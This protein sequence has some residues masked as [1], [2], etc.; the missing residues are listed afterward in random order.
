MNNTLHIFG[1]SYSQLTQEYS[2]GNYY[3]WCNRNTPPTW[4]EILSEKLNLELTN[5]ARQ[6]ESNELIF[7]TFCQKFGKFKKGDVVIFQWSHPQRYTLANKDGDLFSTAYGS[8]DIIPEKMGELLSII[9]TSKG[10]IEQLK[11]YQKVIDYI[12]KTKEVQLWY[13]NGDSTI[14]RYVNP[15]DKRFL[16]FDEIIKYDNIN[17]E[18]N[19]SDV[20]RDLGGCD[21]E[22]ETKGEVKDGHYGGT[23]HRIQAELFYNH[24]KKYQ[25]L[26]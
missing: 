21:I 26:V 8:G 9:K 13:W 6:G 23:S 19:I 7:Q 17:Y 5:Y 18:S 12:C 24:I 2:Y 20:I 15:Y 14:N 3:Q 22:T 25:N 11:H 10:Y 1:C 16:V 4:S